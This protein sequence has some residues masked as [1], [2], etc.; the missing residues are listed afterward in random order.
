[1]SRKDL[2]LEIKE[3]SKTLLGVCFGY[4]IMGESYTF[5]D[6]N[7][8]FECLG[9]ADFF[10]IE[11]SKRRVGNVTSKMIFMAPNYLVG[12]ENHKGATY[13]N[14][15]AIPLSYVDIG[16]G[17]NGSDKTEGAISKNF[18]GTYLTG[19]FL[20]RNVYFTDYLLKVTMETKYREPFE[21]KDEAS[22]KDSI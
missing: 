4:Q 2:F 3:T 21:L 22:N 10:T 11:K 17:N 15:G 6:N 19:P 18:F 20:P 12:F 1:M 9:L 16:Y 7:A 5:K 8:K 13:L 14:K